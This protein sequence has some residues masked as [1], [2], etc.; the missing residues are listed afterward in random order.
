LPI[1]KNSGFM[2]IRIQVYLNVFEI[3]VQDEES[4]FF[5]F[6]KDTYPSSFSDFS[7]DSNFNQPS[8]GSKEGMLAASIVDEIFKDFGN[9]WESNKKNYGA[10]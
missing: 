9:W 4:S 8:I 5:D 3:F 6:L 7:A 10:K 1:E 2:E